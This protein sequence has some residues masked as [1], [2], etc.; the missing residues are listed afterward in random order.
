VYTKDGEVKIESS[1]FE[2]T[3]NRGSA[4]T[5]IL[6]STELIVIIGF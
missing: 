6:E 4:K 1:G 2:A 5:V 3:K